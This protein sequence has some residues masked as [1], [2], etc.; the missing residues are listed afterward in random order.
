MFQKSFLFAFHNSLVQSLVIELSKKIAFKDVI[1]IR[2]WFFH[3]LQDHFSHSL[4]SWT[5]IQNDLMNQNL[6]YRQNFKVEMLEKR[7]RIL[8]SCSIFN[9]NNNWKLINTSMN[10]ATVYDEI[11]KAI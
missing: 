5:N 11:D 9:S 8:V 10:Q 3:I 4:W 7:T 2:N 1:T 6:D